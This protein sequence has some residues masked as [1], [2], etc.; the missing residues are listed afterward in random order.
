MNEQHALRKSLLSARRNLDDDYRDNASLEIQRRFL[1]SRYFFSSQRI[2]CYIAMRDEVDTSM[3][4]DRAW[5]AG[6][7][8]FAPVV[9]PGR[10]LRF[11]RVLRKTPLQ[12]SKFGLW[13]PLHGEEIAPAKLDVVV[14]PGVAIDRHF[15]RIG[16]G[17]G[18]YDRTFSFL[19]D[20]RNWLHPK[21]VG[22]VFDC[23]KV[24]KIAANPWDIRLY[25]AFSESY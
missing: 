15:H 22:L 13:E 14:T 9:V 8:I 4:F 21:L 11:L 2:A 17:G 16:M 10:Q 25:S 3:V 6:K 20:E 12:R 19:R 7:A 18:Y 5:R 23:Q 1:R 24:E